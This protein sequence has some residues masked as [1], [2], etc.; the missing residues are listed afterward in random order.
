MRCDAWPPDTG[1]VLD[2]G[3]IVD[4]D[5]DRDMEQWF[6]SRDCSD[7]KSYAVWEWVNVP[8]GRGDLILPILPSLG[9]EEDREV[10]CRDCIV[11]E[12]D[13]G[14]EYTAFS[15]ILLVLAVRR[16]MEECDGALG[17]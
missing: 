12:D 10:L 9:I 16:E 11:I 15:T 4:M 1:L 2:I 17:V 6:R 5:S 8:P 7:C 13:S 14:E 3:D